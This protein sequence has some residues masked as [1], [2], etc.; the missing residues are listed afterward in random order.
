MAMPYR[1]LDPAL[2]IQNWFNI[3]I[4]HKLQ[5]LNHLPLKY[6]DL[7]RDKSRT[8]ATFQAK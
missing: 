2:F 3:F 5:G 1:A 8:T 7:D 4:T 6:L